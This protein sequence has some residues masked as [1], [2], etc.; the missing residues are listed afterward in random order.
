MRTYRLSK[1]TFLRG[2]QCEKKMYLHHRHPG[3]R[4]EISEAQQAIFTRGIDIGILAQQLFP[5]GVNVKPDEYSQIQESID[6][7]KNLIESGEKI[8]Y[9]AAFQHK[10]A[11]AFIDILV[12]ERSGWHIYEVKSSTR[13]DNVHVLD[14]AFQLNLLLNVGLKVKDVSIVHLNTQYV[15]K[16][17]L[18]IH[19]LF[20]T[21]SVFHQAGLYFTR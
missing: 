4:D 7:T 18:N 14:A 11:L 1:S 20:T 17:D 15:R 5:G 21:I 16:G 3:L 13:V 9:E 8:I 6:K 2:M 10:S 19:E 12:K